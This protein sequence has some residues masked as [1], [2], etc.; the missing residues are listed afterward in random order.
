MLSSREDACW[1]LA[2]PGI[3]ALSV[4][5]R[6]DTVPSGQAL[7]DNELKWGWEE[8]R[9]GGT[10]GRRRDKGINIWTRDESLIHSFM[11]SA[12]GD[13]AGGCVWGGR[14]WERQR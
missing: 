11:H 10:S 12:V 8:W 3:P 14:C 13:I 5:S 6:R 7:G 2:S 1:A 9:N 4:P